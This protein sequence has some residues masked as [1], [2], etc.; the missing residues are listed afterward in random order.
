M[1]VPDN[2]SKKKARGDDVSDSLVLPL[3]SSRGLLRRIPN[4]GQNKEQ[5]PSIAGSYK[6]GGALETTP[7]KPRAFKSI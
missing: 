7:S 1:K 6:W 4:Q 3:E 2:D 5:D